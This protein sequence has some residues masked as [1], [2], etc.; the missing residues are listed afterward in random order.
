MHRIVS[1]QRDPHLE[2]WPWR[3]F[4]DPSPGRQSRHGYSN[5]RLADGRTA[6]DADRRSAVLARLRSPARPASG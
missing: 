1:D 4:E 2:P 6:L 5:R 3:Q